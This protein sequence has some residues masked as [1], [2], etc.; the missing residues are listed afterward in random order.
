MFAPILTVRIFRR[1][2]LFLKELSNDNA[3]TRNILSQ[4]L[5]TFIQT[6]VVTLE[7][8]DFYWN[9]MELWLNLSLEASN[10]GIEGIALI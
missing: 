2:S 5:T 7:N 1:A 8:V 3:F 6:S 10:F 4:E 9:I